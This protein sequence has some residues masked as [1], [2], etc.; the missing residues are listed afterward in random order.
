MIDFVWTCC[1][2]RNSI[3]LVLVS[4]CLVYGGARPPLLPIVIDKT[5]FLE[6]VAY[7]HSF[8]FPFF[9][10]MHWVVVC[11]FCLPLCLPPCCIVKMSP[12]SK[13]LHPLVCGLV[14]ALHC[15]IACVLHCCLVLLYCVVLCCV[16]FCLIMLCLFALHCC[17]AL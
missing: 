14:V 16:M 15:C 7:M 13:L 4:N 9:C 6:V 5:F 3:V 8:L 2:F 17:I 1:H 10:I 11:C 12:V